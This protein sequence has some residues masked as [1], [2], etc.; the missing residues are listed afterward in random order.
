MNESEKP[1]GRPREYDRNEIAQKL[2]EWAKKDNSL[3]LCEF[4]GENLI[5]P[6]KLGVWAKEC[7]YFRS[8]YDIVKSLIAS[9]REKK[10]SKGELHVK[11]YDL[12][13]ATYDYFL[14][15]ERREEKAFEAEIAAKQA[16]DIHKNM[17]LSTNYPETDPNDTRD[18]IQVSPSQLSKTDSMGAQ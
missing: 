15:E 17:C 5:P 12:N 10:L 18:S 1:F 8:S 4:C 9:R 2:I 16:I 14:K 11:A 13:A 7:E 6:Q 3:N